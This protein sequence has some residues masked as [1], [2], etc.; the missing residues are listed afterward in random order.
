MSELL[1]Q[2]TLTTTQQVLQAVQELHALEQIATRETVQAATGLRQTIVD[3]RLRAL[4]DEGKLRRLTRGVYEVTKSYPPPRAMSYTELDDGR[5]KL[6]IADFLVTLTPAETRKLVRGLA[7]FLNDAHLIDTAKTHLRV[8]VDTA[9]DLELVKRE[10]LAL[11]QV[12]SGGAGSVR[13]PE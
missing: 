4:A 10:L 9:T 5:V 6:E 3:D 1:P 12:I 13:P 7:G 2:T 8:A 11:R